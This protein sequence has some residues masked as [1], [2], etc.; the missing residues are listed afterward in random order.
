MSVEGGWMVFLTGCL[1][2]VLCELLH[3]WNLRT[4]PQLP[5]YAKRLRYWVLTVLM[6]VA[7]GAV[8]WLYFGQKVDG[9]VAIHVGLATPLL[10]QKLVGS[11]PDPSGAREAVPRDS[12]KS[13]LSW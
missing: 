2:G 10:L 13:F 8:T 1:G 4:K 7:G 12:V 5:A 3:W 11:V 9:L 6:V